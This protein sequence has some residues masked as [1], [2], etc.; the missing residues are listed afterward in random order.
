[1]VSRDSKLELESLKKTVLLQASN[2]EISKTSKKAIDV[3]ATH[4]KN[5]LPALTDISERIINEELKDYAL[6]KIK[7]INEGKV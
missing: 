4:R 1:M 5:A 6:E 7:Q 3:L 2:K